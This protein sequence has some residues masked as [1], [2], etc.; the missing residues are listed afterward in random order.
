[1]TYKHYLA[2]DTERAVSLSA[3]SSMYTFAGKPERVFRDDDFLDSS[4][5]YDLGLWNDEQMMEGFF[6]TEGIETLTHLMVYL[7]NNGTE[8]VERLVS[9]AAS[10]PE[11]AVLLL[12]GAYE[13]DIASL[14]DAFPNLHTLWLPGAKHMRMSVTRHSHLQRLFVLGPMDDDVITNVSLPQLKSLVVGGQN[15]SQLLNPAC[16]AGQLSSLSNLGLSLKQF[17]GRMSDIRLPAVASLELLDAMGELDETVADVV[18]RPMAKTLKR[19]AIHG[20][21]F[22]APDILNS[23]NFPA[24]SHLTMRFPTSNEGFSYTESLLH[25]KFSQ[26]I[27]LDLRNAGVCDADVVALHEAATASNILSINLAHN[28]VVDTGVALLESLDIPVNLEDQRD[29]DTNLGYDDYDEEEWE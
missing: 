27:H 11:L 19:L 24:L 28:H 6:A 1:M 17:N 2:D 4:Y 10:A 14:L 29:A 20:E 5:A 21:R 8:E 3:S 25:M 7:S 15:V 12:S 26:G 18:T 9:L 13:V 23:D 16:D 22:F